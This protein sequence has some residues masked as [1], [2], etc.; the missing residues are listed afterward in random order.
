MREGAGALERWIFLTGD[1]W[2]AGTGLIGVAEPEGVSDLVRDR[3][4]QVSA[5]E[6]GPHARKNALIHLHV[7]LSIRVE[8]L[9][10]RAG[11]R[12][13]R[14]RDAADAEGSGHAC[15]RTEECGDAVRREIALP[16]DGVEAIRTDESALMAVR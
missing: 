14:R 8:R 11:V 9:A 4:A 6:D 13:R 16:Q 2:I 12:A 7:H 10:V 1:R 15:G 3:R 5:R